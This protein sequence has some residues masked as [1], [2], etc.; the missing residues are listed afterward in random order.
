M[1]LHRHKN[2]NTC[3]LIYNLKIPSSYERQQP[4]VIHQKYAMMLP[5]SYTNKLEEN[6]TYY[7]NSM[8]DI[9]KSVH[10]PIKSTNNKSN[11]LPPYEALQHLTSCYPAPSNEHYPR[12]LPILK[13]QPVPLSM[14]AKNASQAT[15]D[16]MIYRHLQRGNISVQMPN[17][18]YAYYLSNTV[19]NLFLGEDTRYQTCMNYDVARGSQ[20]LHRINRR[21]DYEAMAKSNRE[22]DEKNVMP[23][24]ELVEERI[25]GGELVKGDAGVCS[26]RESRTICT[27]K[28]HKRTTSV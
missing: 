17:N 11:R 6:N 19:P 27:Q 20:R 4:R 26:Q 18:T 9:T 21:I 5:G 24:G 15:Q 23:V 28:N 25:G 22:I 2:K 14:A 10:T 12:V 1:S 3:Q 13:Q 16:Y 7:T 8:N